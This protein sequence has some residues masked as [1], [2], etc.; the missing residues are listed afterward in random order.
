MDV[1]TFMAYLLN[2]FYFYLIIKAKGHKGQFHCSKIHTP[3]QYCYILRWYIVE[4]TVKKNEYTA[5][6]SQHVIVKN[7]LKF[8]LCS[9]FLKIQTD[10]DFT[11]SLHRLF[12]ASMTVLLKKYILTS[13][14]QN[15]F[16]S[17]R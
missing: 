10:G 3:V 14:K 8:T 4:K 11:T 7:L 5:R 6:N 17:L 13:P 12:Q 15:C 9:R 16:L 1:I 2:L